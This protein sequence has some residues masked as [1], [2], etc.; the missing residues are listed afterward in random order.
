MFRKEDGKTPR[1]PKRTSGKCPFCKEEPERVFFWCQGEIEIAE[2]SLPLSTCRHKFHHAE[3]LKSSQV[4]VRIISLFLRESQRLSTVLVK[5]HLQT[6]H[7]NPGPRNKS[8]EAKKLRRE[9]RYEKRKQKK[10]EK[11]REKQDTKDKIVNISTW[12]VQR[13]SLGTR[14]KRKAKSVAEYARKKKWDAVLLSEVRSENR[15]TTWL[16]G[17]ETL[18]AIIHT[19]KAAILLRGR[20]LEKWSEGGQLVKYA[21]RSIA[22]KCGDIVLISTYMPVFRGN[23]E[24]EIIQ[25]REDL[26]NLSQ[27][28]HKDEILIIGG[29]FNAHVGGGEERPG[30][31]GQFGLR[32]SNEQ[33]KS[34]LDWCADN[35]LVH[36]NSYFNSKRRGTWFHM[37]LHRWYELDGFVMRGNQRHKFAKKVYTDEEATIS[38]HRPKILKIETVNK[39][40]KRKKVKKQ[41]RIKFENLK[42]PEKKISYRN[43]VREILEE[44][45][46]N[47]NPDQDEGLQKTNWNEITDIVTEAA[48]DVCGI[49][50]KPIEDPWM[51]DKDEIIQ[52]MRLRISQAITRRNDILERGGDE[53]ER[54]EAIEELKEARRDLKRNTRQWERE[55]WEQII[56]ECREASERGDMGTVYK[57]LKKLGN[58]GK[59]KAPNTTTLTKD[60][61]REHFKK[62]SDTRF[63]NDPEEIDRTLE[64]VEDIRDSEKATQW[65]EQLEEIPSAEEVKEQM[66]KMRD[67]APGEDGVRLSYLLE[68]GPEVFIMLVNMIRFMFVSEADKWEESLK[69]GL[70]IALHKKGNINIPGNYRGVVLLAMGSRV[71]AR[72]LANR[73]RIWAEAMDLLDEEQAG[74][75]KGRST[76]DVTQILVRIQEDTIDL[77]K[78]MEAAGE[79]LEDDEKPAARLLDLRKAYPRV[80]KYAMWKILERYGLGE[81]C[82]RTIRT[83]HETTIYKVKNREGESEAWTTERGLR[84]G[85]PSSPILFNIYHQV[86]MRLAT[87]ERKRKAAEDDLE[88]G[89]NFNWVPGN[90]F[91]NEARWEKKNS[92][93]KRVKIDKGLFADDTTKIGKQK[94]LEQGVNITKEVMASLEERNNDDKEE[95]LIFGEE[96]GDKIRMLGCYIGVQEDLSQ[97]AKRAGHAW[98]QVKPRLK[99]SRMSKKM[100][101]QILEACVESTMLFDC[102]TRTWQ[103]RELKKLQSNVDRMYRY[104]WSHKTKPPLIQMQEEGVNM[105]DVRNE[106]GV[107]SI[108]WKVEKR[109]YER[110]G[111]VLRMKDNRQV[112]TA[113]LGWMEDLERYNKRPGK[114]RKTVLYWKKLVKEA[115]LDVTKIG[116]LT[117]DRDEWRA[118]VRKRMKHLEAWERR[119]GK[120][121]NEERGQRNVRREDT[122]QDLICDWEGCGKAF[123]SKGGLTIHRKR[124][125]EESTEKVTFECELCKATFKQEANLKNHMK[126]CTGLAASSSDRKKCDKCLKEYSKSYFSKHYRKCNAAEASERPTVEATTYKSEMAPCP[127]CGILK[128]K[129]NMSRHRKVCV[130]GAAVP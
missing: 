96:E 18:T 117:A 97:R 6:I 48:K 83:L 26:K 87:K 56:T 65:R 68:A 42:N 99:G 62:V 54:N 119:G 1:R 120:K 66:Q 94:E 21:E 12:N 108:R 78:R 24:I 29:D 102:Q 27:W 92:E 76:A 41:P 11:N 63:E 35:N 101:A 8:E 49:A 14:N 90:S 84:E 93:A 86:S 46:A 109:V 74:F 32:V 81:N 36:V 77:R 52:G 57:T 69:M 88:V 118:T 9:R 22:V 80:N 25:A 124:I 111:H 126:R 72:I 116:M 37:I 71:L 4:L 115:G 128:A 114:K 15:G 123:R 33:G 103:Q 55:W 3:T 100:Q 38:D 67:S 98:S 73:L 95:R 127:D 19:Q 60:D 113:V 75:R 121:V 43:R 64:K 23:N 50:E 47:G 110:I 122:A 112:K 20:L 89:L 34:L 85:C 105:Q 5:I 28:A 61:F 79:V 107:K 39:M 82:L 40:K 30:V 70:V 10:E 51:A 129:T 104:V 16:G 44:R 17:E 45:E 59:T 58:R 31:C 91:P 13:M 125:H 106:L 2:L 130:M 7:P 53:N